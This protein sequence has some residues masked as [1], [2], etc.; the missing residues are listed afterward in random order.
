MSHNAAF[1]E[2]K[3]NAFI[4][5]PH[6]ARG[7]VEGTIDPPPGT[8]IWV[9]GQRPNLNFPYRLAAI[10]PATWTPILLADIPPIYG[11]AIG[12][13]PLSVAGDADHAVVTVTGT[14]VNSSGAP[15]S[16]YL[17][18][19]EI[20][21]SGAI[22]QVFSPAMPYEVYTGDL[23]REE[24]VV[25]LRGS[26]VV[27]Q[28][29]PLA[30]PFGEKVGNW[31]IRGSLGIGAGGAPAFLVDTDESPPPV[32]R[33]AHHWGPTT[34]GPIGGDDE[35]IHELSFGAL[36]TYFM[37]PA[38]SPAG[39]AQPRLSTLVAGPLLIGGTD[40]FALS[41]LGGT[42]GVIYGA[43]FSRGE[44]YQIDQQLTSLSFRVGPNPIVRPVD[45]GGR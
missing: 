10:D 43:A 39:F 22:V 36:V 25:G 34:G 11:N 26:R 18:H 42:V 21:L 40:L 6:N 44:L 35:Y 4:E 9:V 23:V 27:A 5:S 37:E 31:L 28:V 12:Q 29:S 17:N 19:L 32:F 38:E 20:D 45:V 15:L 1:C 33:F 7:C 3:Q 30:L 14:R 41:A 16:S 8:I 24:L 2:G 13:E